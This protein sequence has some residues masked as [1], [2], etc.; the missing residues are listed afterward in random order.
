MENRPT[1]FNDGFLADDTATFWYS[2][3]LTM[4]ACHFGHVKLQNAMIFSSKKILERKL[5]VTFIIKLYLFVKFIILLCMALK[6]VVY[7]FCRMEV[8]MSR[9][10]AGP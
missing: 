10:V 5:R 8:M 4:A 3:K 1:H 6:N 7:I 9:E 2:C